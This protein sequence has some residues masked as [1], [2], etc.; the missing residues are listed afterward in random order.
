VRP[1]G[2]NRVTIAVRD[3]ER[4][5]EVFSRLLGATFHPAGEEDAARFGVRVAISWDAGIELVSPLPGRESP[6]ARF[7]EERGEGLMGVVFAVDDLGEARRRAEE[8]GVPVWHEL[9]Y[10]QEEIDRRLQ[11]RFSR[12]REIML[13]SRGTCGVAPVIGEFAPRGGA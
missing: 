5:K 9:D 8:M 10:S 2:I 11:G 4:G 7:L 1:L 13:G 12:Y 3:L 6:V